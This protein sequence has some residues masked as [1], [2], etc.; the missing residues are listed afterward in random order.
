[1]AT[2]CWDKPGPRNP[3]PRCAPRAFQAAHLIVPHMRRSRGPSAAPL[4]FLYHLKVT[5]CW[6]VF[7]ERTGDGAA[8]RQLADSLVAG[9][10]GACRRQG[11]VR[12]MRAIK[13]A[14]GCF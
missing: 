8:T 11:G 14:P 12:L 5:D 7:Y 2:T 3:Y 1:M 13:A 6:E 4:P 9:M 10:R